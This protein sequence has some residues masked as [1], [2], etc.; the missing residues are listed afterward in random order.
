LEREELLFFA[1]FACLLCGYSIADLQP[2]LFSFYNPAGTC[3]TYDG[4]EVEQFFDATKVLVTLDRLW[5]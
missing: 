2:R 3:P 4:L 5:L 1:S